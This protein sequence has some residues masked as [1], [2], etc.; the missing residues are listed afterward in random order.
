MRALTLILPDLGYDT[1]QYC[2][3]QIRRVVCQYSENNGICN[4]KRLTTALSSYLKYLVSKDLC[5]Y[6]LIA[7]IPT[8][9]EFVISVKTSEIS[10]LVISVIDD[11]SIFSD[12]FVLSVFRFAADADV[13]VRTI[14]RA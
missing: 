6:A 11:E 2:A 7:S 4:T 13:S 10:L 12:V 1:N 14:V 3:Q 5:P 8:V 9:V